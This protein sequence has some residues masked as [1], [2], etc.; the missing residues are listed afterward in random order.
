MKKDPGSHEVFMFNRVPNLSTTTHVCSDHHSLAQ[1]LTALRNQINHVQASMCGRRSEIERLPMQRPSCAEA[2]P[3]PVCDLVMLHSVRPAAELLVEEGHGGQLSPH[4]ATSQSDQV[5]LGRD[6]QEHPCQSSERAHGERQVDGTQGGS[7]PTWPDRDAGHQHE[8]CRLLGA[9]G[10]ER[11]GKECE[12]STHQGLS[13]KDQQDLGRDLVECNQEVCGGA[14]IGSPRSGSAGTDCASSGGQGLSKSGGQDQGEEGAADASGDRLFVGHDDLGRGGGNSDCGEAKGEL[15]ALWSSL[16]SLRQRIG[17][18][19]MRCGL[20]DKWP[21]NGSCNGHGQKQRT[22]DSAVQFQGSRPY[23]QK[24]NEGKSSL[25][26]CSTAT[27]SV[28][29]D[30]PQPGPGGGKRHGVPP[31]TARKLATNVAVLGAMMLTPLRE[32]LHQ[33]DGSLD[34]LEVACSPTSSLSTQ[35]Q[36]YGYTIQR[37]NVKEGYDL[38]KKSG[39]SKLGDLIRLKK[40]KHTWISLPCTRLTS[41]SNLTKR[42]DWEEAAFQKRRGRDLQRAHEIACNAEPILE[43]GD[44]LSWE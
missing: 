40:P 18:A 10:I 15:S 26:S 35:M 7:T 20:N 12:A 6:W 8:V 34:F 16:R 30:L 41:L 28:E 13:G 2:P 43:S 32:V 14:V 24:H 36:E 1:R 38:E 19:T 5:G 37:I 44:D 31:F 21:D 9:H 22:L 25:E 4:G 23:D 39:T 3:E 27:N 42:D 33:M 11:S 17:G 29:A